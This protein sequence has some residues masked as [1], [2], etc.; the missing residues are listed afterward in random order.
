MA[1]L[2]FWPKGGEAKLWDVGDITTPTYPRRPVTAVSIGSSIPV[3]SR[4]HLG[5]ISGIEVG[6]GGIH[7]DAGQSKDKGASYGYDCASPATISQK[8][9]P[10]NSGSHFDDADAGYHPHHNT[11]PLYVSSR[12][13]QGAR[14]PEAGAPAATCTIT[15]RGLFDRWKQPLPTSLHT[16]ALLLQSRMT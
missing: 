14:F 2:W 7:G 15:A 1:Y 11:D 3:P 5:K 12:E 10:F 13:Q 8:Q 9:S 4:A 16:T 6:S